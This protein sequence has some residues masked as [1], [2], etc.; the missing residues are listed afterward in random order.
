MPIAVYRHMD[1]PV[2]GINKGLREQAVIFLNYTAHP[3]HIELE[4]RITHLFLYTES[5]DDL[6]RGKKIS[7][8]YA[9]VLRLHACPC[10]H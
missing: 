6:A 10:S 7:I 9:V 4:I 2:I 1:C 3:A 8:S 5:V